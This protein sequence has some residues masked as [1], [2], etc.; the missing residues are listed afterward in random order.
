MHAKEGFCRPTGALFFS[1]QYMLSGRNRQKDVFALSVE[2]RGTI[3][4]AA[5]KRPVKESE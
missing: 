2:R 5:K 4:H 1:A 3:D